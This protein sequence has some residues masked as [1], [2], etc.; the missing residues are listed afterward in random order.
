M[1]RRLLAAPCTLLLLGLA[2]GGPSTERYAVNPEAGNNTFSAVFDAPLG[3]RINAVSS[4]VGCDLTYDPT[5]LAGGGSCS[6]PLTSIRVDGDAT[7]TDHFQQW[8]TNKKVD[9]ASCRFELALGSVKLSS[10]LKPKASVPFTASGTLTV[11]GRH[12]DPA[13][14]ETITGSVMLFPAGSYGSAQTLR[15]RAH[16]Q[17][18]DRES[19]G[20]SPQ[21]TAGWLARVQQLAPVVAAKGDIDFS[22]FAR[23]IP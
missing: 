16:I 23:L 18:F 9:P 5:T 12:R 13:G 1:R 19:Y 15:I 21:A 2:A 6:V 7:K 8:A 17:G 20:I 4:E 22:L 3:E 10:V 11:C 14:P